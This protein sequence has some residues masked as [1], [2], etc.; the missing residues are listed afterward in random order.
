MTQQKAQR[1]KHYFH[2]GLS[3]LKETMKALALTP[4]ARLIYRKK[5]VW[6]VSERGTDARDNGYHFFR[7]LRTQHPEINSYYVISK[8][9][10]DR[11]RLTS[12]GHIVDYRSLKHYLLFFGAEKLISSHIMGFSPQ[13]N[14]YL[15]CQAKGRKSIVK[16]KTVFLQHGV[17]KDNIPQLYQENT[18]LDLFICGAKPEYEYITDNWHYEN[19]EVQYTG[20]ARFDALHDFHTKRQILIMP[21]W[22]SWLEHS[23]DASGEKLLK[24]SYF[25]H[26]NGFLKSDG[27]KELV[28]KYDVS[29]IFY[30]HYA[31]QKYIDRFQ[32]ASSRV[33]VADFVHYD[34]QQLL[35]ESMLLITDYSSV[36]FD[37]A[38]MRKPVVYYQ[39]D[40]EEYRAQ[41]YKQGYFDYRRDGFGEVVTEE[42]ALLE[43]MEQYLEN[44][45]ALKESYQKRIEGFFPL[46]D[47][48]NCERIYDEIAGLS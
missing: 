44:G 4:V 9:A 8:D 5:H 26:W 33:I 41:H 12:L 17:T 6:L 14:F 20:F 34:V 48:K 47:D 43:L 22:R 21:T 30:P 28:E 27:L 13:N 3:F 38:Y 18:K 16:G 36:F 7:Y 40:E 25:Q 42:K 39:F 23:A 46:H 10:A 31:V 32:S 45:C 29:F 19:D 24:S 15:Y 35:K 2:L 11:D 37:F 1:V